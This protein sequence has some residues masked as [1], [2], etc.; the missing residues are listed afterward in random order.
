MTIPWSEAVEEWQGV[1]ERIKKTSTGYTTSTVLN[2]RECIA[3]IEV[4]LV[5]ASEMSPARFSPRRARAHYA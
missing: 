2:Q 5:L 4:M 3:V 1:L